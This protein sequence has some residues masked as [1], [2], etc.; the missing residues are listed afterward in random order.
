M[1]GRDFFLPFFSI[2]AVNAV[3]HKYRNFIAGRKKGGGVGK[4]NKQKKESLSA[5]EV[6]TLHER[7]REKVN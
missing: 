4:R 6:E 2:T 1:M 5:K 3:E 7:K